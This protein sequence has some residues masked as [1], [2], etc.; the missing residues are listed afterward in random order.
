MTSRSP[1]TR[2][3]SRPRSTAL[4]ACFGTVESSTVLLAF[5]GPTSPAAARHGIGDRQVGCHVSDQRGVDAVPC[6]PFCG[7]F[8][9]AVVWVTGRRGVAIGEQRAEQ[10]GDDGDEARGP[11]VGPASRHGARC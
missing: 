8:S 5:S 6:T 3:I 4:G 11:V 1:P 10:A 2:S 7:Q 9:W